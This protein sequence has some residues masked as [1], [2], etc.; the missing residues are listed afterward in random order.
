MKVF[1]TGLN[2]TGTKTL[3][4]CFRTFGF[5]NQSYDLGLLKA[6]AR[7]DLEE[8]FR[9]S[10]RFDSFEDWPWPL[11]YREFDRRYPDAKFIL[12][13]RKDPETWFDSLCRH[14]ELTGPTEAREIVYG[15][16][17]PHGHREHHIGIY[18]KHQEE[19]TRYFSD[20]PGKLLVISWDRGEGWLQ[21]CP[22]LGIS[23]IPQ[24][25]FPHENQGQHE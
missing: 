17:M 22:F 9:V 3:G 6:W 5:H 14:A 20:R 1:G 10:D 8:I 24:R 12:T 4:E 13:L 15:H 11:L 23:G 19:V 2:K 25:P 16:R 18:L 21:L 7:G